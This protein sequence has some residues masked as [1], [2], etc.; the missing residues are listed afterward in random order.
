MALCDSASTA[1][2]TNAQLRVKCIGTLE[3]LAMS[4][5]PSSYRRTPPSRRSCGDRAD[6]AGRRVTDRRLLGRGWDVNFCTGRYLE[7][8][9]GGVVGVKTAV[10]AIDRR[11]EGG[12]EL[13]RRGEEVRDSL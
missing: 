11:K 13:R 8:L 6:A 7:R 9:A 5:A 12:R 1:A 2:D 10:R 4:P 3:C